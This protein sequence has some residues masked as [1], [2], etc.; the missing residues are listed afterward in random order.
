MDI[1]FWGPPFPPLYLPITSLVSFATFRVAS[2][3]PFLPLLHI[4][5]HLP[6]T[7]PYSCYQPFCFIVSPLPWLSK[8]FMISS[9]FSSPNSRAT[10]SQISSCHQNCIQCLLDWTFLFWNMPCSLSCFSTGCFFFLSTFFSSWA[11]SPFKPHFNYYFL[12]ISYCLF[13]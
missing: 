3:S 12:D 11:N 9:Q 2:L 13:V 4:L 6:E 10:T 8:P 5:W 7:Q 1:I